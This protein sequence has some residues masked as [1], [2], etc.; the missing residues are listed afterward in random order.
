MGN[1]EE[2]EIGKGEKEENGKGERNKEMG[3]G[4]SEKKEIENKDIDII[5]YDD[6]IEEYLS[7]FKE[8]NN[9]ANK[10]NRFSFEKTL[11]VV[12]LNN[13][14]SRNIAEDIIEQISDVDN[15]Y[16]RFYREYNAKTNPEISFQYNCSQRSDLNVIHKILHELPKKVDVSEH[17]KEFITQNI[18]LLLKEIYARLL[19]KANFKRNSNAFISAKALLKEYNCTKILDINLPVQAIAFET[20]LHQMLIENNISIKKCEIDATYNTNNLGFELYVMHAEVNGIDF[21]LAYLFLE[22]DEKCGDGIKTEMIMKFVLHLK[23]KGLD[24][25]FILTDKDWAQIKICNST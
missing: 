8:F 11:N 23:E 3:M 24:P 7:I 12:M 14:F 21:S 9:E 20:G 18:D 6:L 4:K 17:V 19:E 13:D 10:E 15:F 1:G 25:N 2:K 5:E 22:H 16:R